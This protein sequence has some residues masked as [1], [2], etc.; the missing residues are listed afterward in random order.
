MMRPPEDARKG[1]MRPAVK[2][3]AEWS[4]SLSRR[5]PRICRLAGAKGQPGRATFWYRPRNHQLVKSQRRTRHRIMPRHLDDLD[6]DH[7][8]DTISMHKAS[9]TFQHS[10]NPRPP[11]VCGFC[12]RSFVSRAISSVTIARDRRRIII[13]QWQSTK[14]I[15]EFLFDKM[16]TAHGYSRAR[17]LFAGGEQGERRRRGHK[18]DMEKARKSNRGKSRTF[19]RERAVSHSGISKDGNVVDGI[20]CGD[21]SLCENYASTIIVANTPFTY[22]CSLIYDFL[23]RS[24]THRPSRGPPTRS[25]RPVM[26]DSRNDERSNDTLRSDSKPHLQAPLPDYPF[27]PLQSFSRVQTSHPPSQGPPQPRVMSIRTCVQRRAV[28]IKIDKG[29]SYIIRAAARSPGKGRD[30]RARLVSDLSLAQATYPSQ[31]AHP[32]RRGRRACRRYIA[33]VPA[34]RNGAPPRTLNRKSAWKLRAGG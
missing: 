31:E 28:H 1:G 20:A 6:H 25:D 19:T 4:W 23:P 10:R 18:S 24:R 13:R 15:N 16:T 17:P 5:G 12:V 34:R 7:V 8:E 22:E 26:N 29:G 30:L 11:F 21:V 32:A 2:G 14:S 3:P 27:S 33:N 9:N